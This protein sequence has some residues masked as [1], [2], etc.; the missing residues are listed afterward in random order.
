M[1][2]FNSLPSPRL[3]KT[4]AP[5]PLLVGCDE[6]DSSGETA[7]AMSPTRASPSSQQQPRFVVV[8]RNPKDVVTS[9]YYHAFNPCKSG[10]PFA[11]WV[12]AWLAGR[13]P[14]GDW[15]AWVRGWRHRAQE[16]GPR[17]CLILTYEDLTAEDNEVLLFFSHRPTIF[18]FTLTRNLFE[19]R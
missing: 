9:A 17:R 19:R 10:W 6:L 15:V 2:T 3:I 13:T 8:V 18:C 11:A 14:A 16:L 12:A 7:A 1:A 4:H 5:V